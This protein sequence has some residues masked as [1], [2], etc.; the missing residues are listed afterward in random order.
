MVP[1]QSLGFPLSGDLDPEPEIAIAVFFLRLDVVGSKHYEGASNAQ[2][3]NPPG[4]FQRC[5]RNGNF[6]AGLP[7][8]MGEDTVLLKSSE[9]TR[10]KS[11]P[12]D[13]SKPP[14]GPILDPTG[15]P[16]QIGA[17]GSPY[18]VTLTLNPKSQLRYVPSA[19]TWS[20]LSTTRV[21][22]VPNEHGNDFVFYRAVEPD[23]LIAVLWHFCHCCHSAACN[24]RILSIVPG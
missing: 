17:S 10:V 8:G 16:R 14:A 21:R 6:R 19:W 3:S 23:S 13:H 9:L 7:L 2:P 11:V 22:I 18:P 1:P 12:G 20:A 4:V 24:G 5:F 15:Y